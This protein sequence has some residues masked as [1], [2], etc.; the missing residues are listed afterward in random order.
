MNKLL[1]FGVRTI[2][3]LQQVGNQTIR[4]NMNDNLIEKLRKLLRL[5][6]SSNENESKLATDINIKQTT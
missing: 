3:C 4:T 1:T 6:E 2:N 5:T